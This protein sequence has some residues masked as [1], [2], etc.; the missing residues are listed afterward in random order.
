MGHFFFRKSRFWSRISIFVKIIDKYRFWWKFSKSLHLS[1]KNRISQLWSNF[2]KIPASDRNFENLDLI[3]NFPKTRLWLKFSKYLDFRQ[4]FRKSSI[5]RQISILVEIFEK[6]RFWSKFSK[7]LNF[8]QNFQGAW[9]WL[10]FLRKIS[11]LVKFFIKNFEN[12][13]FYSK[14]SKDIDFSLTLENLDSG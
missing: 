6:C 1:K 9:F 10:N 5:L 12:S 3:Q 14:F 8:S 2:S 11:I 13:R 7:N 4:N